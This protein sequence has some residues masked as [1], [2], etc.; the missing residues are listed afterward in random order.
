MRSIGGGGSTTIAGLADSE[1]GAR[2]GWFIVTQNK[3]GITVKIQAMALC[4]GAGKAVAA[5]APS[6][7]ANN[8][9]SP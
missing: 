8:P 2:E 1:T 7:A 5:K 6:H 3:S 4:A 9:G